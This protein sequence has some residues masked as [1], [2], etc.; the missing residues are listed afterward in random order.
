MTSSECPY[1]DFDNKEIQAIAGFMITCVHC[2]LKFDNPLRPAWSTP[3]EI[4]LNAIR[5]FD[6]YPVLDVCANDDNHR[7]PEYI[8]PKQD[9]LK[10]AWTKNAFMN[11]PFDEIPLWMER[12]QEQSFE[13]HINVIA[14]LPA[15][16]DSKWWHLHIGD[17]L[18]YVKDYYFLDKRVDFLIHGKKQ[19]GNHY[20]MPCVIVLI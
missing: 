1:C 20:R 5:R 6:V 15:Y 3:P 9:G 14:I 16:T 13:N 18:Q 2:G 17:K 11:C 4:I 7:L 10:T 8:T 19:K 12:A